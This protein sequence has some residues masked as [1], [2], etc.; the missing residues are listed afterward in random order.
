MRRG[1]AGVEF[2]LCWLDGV[3]AV[4]RRWEWLVPAA[5]YGGGPFLRLWFGVGVV[6]AVVVVFA[7]HL[8][9]LRYEERLVGWLVGWLVIR[10]YIAGGEGEGG[11]FI[12]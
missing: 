6:C 3:R 5:D 10:N 7:G 12:T 11:A 2:L 4:T 9:K 8:V 1:G